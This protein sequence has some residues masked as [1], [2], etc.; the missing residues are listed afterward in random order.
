[1]RTSRGTA[2]LAPLG[3]GLLLLGAALGGCGDGE[4]CV[5]CAAG[6]AC[7]A[8][9]PS[10]LGSFTSVI[11]NCTEETVLAG[12]VRIQV[13]AN[14]DQNMILQAENIQVTL[15]DREGNWTVFA[16][17]A[18]ACAATEADA[19]STTASRTYRFQVT[20]QTAEGELRISNQLD[21]QYLPGAGSEAGLDASYRVDLLDTKDPKKSCFISAALKANA[22]TGP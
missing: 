15:T 17:T 11:T 5:P 16:G 9:A 3:A 10:Y 13:E 22:G 19:T 2:G 21:G 14:Q 7:P 6:I 18:R 1:M 4:A 8:L 12:E 20:Y